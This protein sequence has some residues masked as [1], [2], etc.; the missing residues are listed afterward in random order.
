MLFTV[1]NHDVPSEGR[2]LAAAVGEFGDTDMCACKS[3]M[4]YSQTS[5]PVM[6]SLTRMKHY[7]D[8]ML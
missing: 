6:M 3:M 5:L 2:V 1:E 8:T 7:Y 4:Y